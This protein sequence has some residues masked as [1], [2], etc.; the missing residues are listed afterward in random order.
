MKKIESVQASSC[1][2]APNARCLRQLTF[3][4]AR[5]SLD[6]F[7]S[8]LAPIHA[9]V[10]ASA[11]RARYYAPDRGYL[12]VQL[13]MSKTTDY[14]GGVASLESA[15]AFRTPLVRQF[16]ARFQPENSDVLSAMG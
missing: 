5:R 15:V 4:Q 10:R 13:P 12:V 7:T 1:G 16:L 2:N 6:D 11:S 9:V 14:L 8:R 3:N